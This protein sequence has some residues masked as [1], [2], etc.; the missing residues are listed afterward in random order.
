MGSQT[1]GGTNCQ[2]VSQGLSYDCNGNLT[3]DGTYTFTYDAENR[4]LT[5]S[6]TGLAAAYAY[7]PLGRR[8]KKSGTGVTTTYYLSDGTDEIAEYG[9]AQ[10][11]TTR[12]IPGPT[13][14]EPI[15]IQN[16]STGTK[17]FFHTD[18]QGSVVAMSDSFGALVEGPYIYDSY[19]NCFSSGS[20]CSSGGEPYRYI[21]RRFDPET[22]CLYYR[23]RYYCSDD[24]HGGRFLQTDSVGYRADL[25]LYTYVANDPVNKT[26]AMGLESDSQCSTGSLIPNGGSSAG[27][28]FVDGA[29]P[30]SGAGKLDK[31]RLPRNFE[32]ETEEEQ[33]GLP[34]VPMIMAGPAT[35]LGAVFSTILRYPDM[36]AEV[37]Q[38]QTDFWRAG[39]SGEMEAQD[40]IIANGHQIVGVQVWVRTSIGIRITDFLITGG[41]LSPGTYGGIEVKVNNSGYTAKQKAKDALLWKEGGVVISRNSPLYGQH[42]KYDTG[43]YRIYTR[44]ED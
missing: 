16:V 35:G 10:I 24:Q 28:K 38:N 31:K 29:T 12:I 34:P 20:A 23:A 17:E 14:D 40:Q 21:G 4:L 30:R 18:K 19:G 27:C 33:S 13:I 43:E 36:V 32:G 2:G 15:A 44:P 41:G 26:D 42:I 37:A 22:G 7:D 3:F 25:N 11:V 39:K 1:A 6:K 8:T 9:S 5:A